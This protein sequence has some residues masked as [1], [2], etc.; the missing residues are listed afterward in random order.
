VWSSDALL[1]Y[2]DPSARDPAVPLFF[3]SFFQHL[4]SS[5]P[6]SSSL[7]SLGLGSH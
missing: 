5:S 6:S 3:S 1:A 7:S 2:L 4:S